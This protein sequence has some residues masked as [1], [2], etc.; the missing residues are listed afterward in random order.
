MISKKLIANESISESLNISP[1]QDS[2]VAVGEVANVA[3][4]AWG[5]DAT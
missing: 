2:F 1:D 4:K 5:N 3:S